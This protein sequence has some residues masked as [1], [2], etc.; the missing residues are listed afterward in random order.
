ML[1]VRPLLFICRENHHVRQDHNCV[2]FS[3]L[4]ESLVYVIQEERG[5]VFS[6]FISL[7]LHDLHTLQNIV[8]LDALHQS[9]S[10]LLLSRTAK[11]IIVA[12]LTH[13]VD[14]Q[15]QQISDVHTVPDRPQLST[16]TYF[17]MHRARHV[18]KHSSSTFDRR[19][20]RSSCQL[21]SLVERFVVVVQDLLFR[22]YFRDYWSLF[23]GPFAAY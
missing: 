8:L 3:L 21:E 2:H 7:I 15:S 14:H 4:L 10:R 12:L 13:I 18:H 5:V 17:A 19:N 11:Y 6:N 23:V 22:H 9:V 16:S 1:P 20:V